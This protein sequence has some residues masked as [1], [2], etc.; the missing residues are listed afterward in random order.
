VRRLE[1]IHRASELFTRERGRERERIRVPSRDPHLGEV[2]EFMRV[3][4]ALDHALH[5]GSKRMRSQ[6][7]VTGPQR[8][9]IRI[10]GRFPELTAGRLAALLHLHPSTLTGVRKRL[11][12]QGLL[13]RRSDPADRRRCLLELTAKGRRLNV[14]TAGTIEAGVRR[15]LNDASPRQLDAARELLSA[16]AR[17][18][19]GA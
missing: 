2:L 15:A 12:A 8:F 14:E 5:R 10:V 18:L 6:L 3:M 17:E 11:E 4:W 1:S 13:R 16:I 7:G 19:E 9:V